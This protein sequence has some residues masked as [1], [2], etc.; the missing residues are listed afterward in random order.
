[1]TVSS[2]D[3]PVGRRGVE[4]GA[5]PPPTVIRPNGCI[6]AIVEPDVAVWLTT[7]SHRRVSALCTGWEQFRAPSPTAP[8]RVIKNLAVGGRL[9]PMSRV[10]QWL[11]KCDLEGFMILA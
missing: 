3:G 8:V 10:H 6:P 2:G 7:P 4:H 5:V 1:M 9:T 11:P